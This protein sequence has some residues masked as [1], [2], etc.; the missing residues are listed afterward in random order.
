M[1]YITNINKNYEWLYFERNERKRKYGNILM[2]LI[3]DTK[4]KTVT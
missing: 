2:I 4:Q 3:I 1:R